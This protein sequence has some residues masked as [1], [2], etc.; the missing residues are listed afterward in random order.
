MASC[1][2]V[3]AAGTSCRRPPS[4]DSEYCLAHD[5]AR[6]DEHAEAS[7]AG[8]VARHD[9]ETLGFKAEVRELMAALR[10]GDVSAGVGSVLLQGFRLLR[11]IDHADRMEA[12]ADTLVES[13]QTMRAGGVPDM[14]EPPANT[15]PGDIE[16]VDDT[17]EPYD[18]DAPRME[19]YR[20]PDGTLDGD[21]F[22]SDS[23]AHKAVPL[24]HLTIEQRRKRF[25]SNRRG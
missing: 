7:R 11:E 8:G 12:S 9:P 25:A 23:H 22:L 3:T 19:D 1:K 16:A 17:S 24:S 20:R 14:S 6:V 5:P 21:A 4:R 13:I 10:R 2:G 15:P 18:P